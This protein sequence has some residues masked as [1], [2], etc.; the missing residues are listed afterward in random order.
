MSDKI[1]TSL[2]LSKILEII[3]ITLL[4]LKSIVEFCSFSI[5]SKISL[6]VCEKSFEISSQMYLYL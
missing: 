6:Y 2:L 1:I 4:Y 3:N 5:L